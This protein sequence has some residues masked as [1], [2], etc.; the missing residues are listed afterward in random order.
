MM[1]SEQRKVVVSVY[2]HLLANETRGWDGLD[3]YIEYLDYLTDD[4]LH[5]EC[6]VIHEIHSRGQVKCNVDHPKEKC[7][8]PI[9]FDAVTAILELYKE[10]NNLHPKNKYILQYYLAMQQAD[11]IV[12]E[13]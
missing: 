7:F 1:N 3:D 6:D 4:Q 10:T 12:V 11:M 5:R 13:G 8:V 9:M 2:N